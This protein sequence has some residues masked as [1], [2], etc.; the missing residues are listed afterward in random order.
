VAALT[1]GALIVAL[2]LAGALPPAP[3][4]AVEDPAEDP[5]EI[6]PVGCLVL[7]G[8]PDDARV[9][10]DGMPVSD[11]DHARLSDCLPMAPGAYLVTVFPM[12]APPFEAFVDVEAG[13]AAHV[14]YVPTEAVSVDLPPAP[15][16]PPPE[17]RMGPT[18]IAGAFVAAGSAVVFWQLSNRSGLAAEQTRLRD[19]LDSVTRARIL[20]DLQHRQSLRRDAA[21]ISAA[22]GAAL[23]VAGTVSWSL[24][25]GEGEVAIQVGPRYGGILAE[26][27]LP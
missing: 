6:A 19:D 8:L 11:E 18:L 12:A 27:R 3:A 20:A 17:P 26:V 9:E 24:A 7:S 13:G 16:L 1:R 15:P 22:A 23:L 10:I 25:G 5:D 2:T 14:R 4:F 21:T